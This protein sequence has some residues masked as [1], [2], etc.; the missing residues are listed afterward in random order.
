MNDKGKRQSFSG[1]ETLTLNLKKG[2]NIN[3]YC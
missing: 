2:N 3:D 1:I